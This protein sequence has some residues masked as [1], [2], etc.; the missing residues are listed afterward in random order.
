MARALIVSH[1]W[2]VAMFPPK[3]KFGMEFSQ[4][5]GIEFIGG[6]VFGGSRGLEPPD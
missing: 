5:D 2:F 3:L 4:G 1:G 6:L